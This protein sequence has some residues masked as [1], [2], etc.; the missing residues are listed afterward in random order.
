M[1]DS[2]DEDHNILATADSA[3]EASE[4]IQIILGCITWTPEDAD[5]IGGDQTEPSYKALVRETFKGDILAGLLGLQSVG[6]S[7]RCD[8]GTLRVVRE[9]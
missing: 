7:F 5:E 8:K 1:D 2:G 9:W 4:T 6:I 3:G